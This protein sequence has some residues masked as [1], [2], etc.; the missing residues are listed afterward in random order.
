MADSSLKKILIAGASGSLGSAL[1]SAISNN[2]S[3]TITVLTRASSRS[4]FPSNLVVKTVSD[5]FTVAELTTAFA[6]QDAVINALSTEPMA[7]DELQ[8]RFVDAAIAAGVQRYVT[9]DFGADN[10]N[11]A[12]QALVPVFKAKGEVIEYLKRRVQEPDV[13]LTWTAIG[14]GSWLD[15]AL[16]KDF[17]KINIPG[18]K[19]KIFD[20]GT[21]KFTVTTLP[22][23]ALATARILQDPGRTANRYLYFQDFACSSRDIVAELERQSGEKWELEHVSSE[24]EIANAREGI[25]RGDVGAMYDLLS[26]SFVGD[27][28][29]PCGTWFEETGLELANELIGGLPKVTLGDVVREVLDRN[30]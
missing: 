19:A 10:T 7:R 1:L 22:N 25:A 29:V 26:I 17:F 27:A 24:R 28:E 13:T 21:H 14:T 5:A 20:S 18:R 6:G 8:M 9:G 11:A 30:K 15:W 2:P 16:D 23:V 4:R 12:A 3:I